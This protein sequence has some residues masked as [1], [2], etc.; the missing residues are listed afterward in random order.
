MSGSLERDLARLESGPLDPGVTVLEAS[1]GTGKTYQITNLVL[2]LVAE[3]GVTMG[4]ILVVTFTNAAT[5]E[6]RDRIRDRLAQA[7]RAL[8]QGSSDDK[9]LDT[10]VGRAGE[11]RETWTRAVARAQEEFDQALISTI[12]GFCQRMLQQHAFESGEEFGLELITDDADLLDELV[13]DYLSARVNTLGAP[14]YAFLVDDCGMDRA[15]LRDV[16][17]AAVSDPDMAL[18]PPAAESPPE[19]WQAELRGLRQAWETE[20]AALAQRFDRGRPLKKNLKDNPGEVIFSGMQ[21]TYTAKATADMEELLLAW[22]D[23]S[24]EQDIL[25]GPD[26]A[27]MSWFDQ[28]RLE[29]LLVE[30]ATF[31]SR[32][33]ALALAALVEAAAFG[34]VR[35]S[36]LV[37]APW[38][39]FAGWVRAEYKRRL[40]QRRSLCFQDLLR[41]LDLALEQSPE[42]VEAIRGRFMAG[43]IDEFQDTDHLQWRIFRRLF[44]G[45][46]R[47]LYLIGDPK[48][49]IYG[50]R[51]ANVH[52]YAAARGDEPPLTIR[53]NYRS[54]ARYVA[55]MNAVMGRWPA[56]LFGHPGI[57][58]VQVGANP[59]RE[60]MDRLIPPGG[61]EADLDVWQDPAA[62]PLQLRFFGDG[63]E[64]GIEGEPGPGI[65][66][67]PGPLTK[68]R[69]GEM[70]PARVAAD[71]VAFL[72]AGFTIQQD[73]DKAPVPV[74]PGDLA[75]LVRGN[76]QAD[77]M[78]AALG[79]AGVPAVRAGAGS[80]FASEEAGHLLQWLRA[81]ASPG[82]DR[83]VRAAAVSPAFGWTA[84]QLLDLDDP[85]QDN[86]RWDLWLSDLVRWQEMIYKHG[87]Q[88]AF[89]RAMADWGVHPRLLALPDG[90]RRITN[91]LHLL[92]L[93]YAAQLDQRLRLD[94]LVRWLSESRSR[95]DT[96]QEVA[97][98]RLERD[99][100]AVKVLTMH[101]SKGLQYPVVFAPFLW[102]GR[103]VRDADRSRLVHPVAEGATER[104]LELQRPPYPEEHQANV[105][106]AEHEAHRE[107]MR[108]L[109]VALTR[110]RLRCVLY[111]GPVTA[112]DGVSGLTRSPLGV[113]LHGQDPDVAAD[114]GA[115]ARYQ[116][117]V[118]RIKGMSAGELR[119]DLD[120]W[121]AL[122]RWR[123][124]GA[125]GGEPPLVAVSDAPLPLE[126]VAKY[127]PAGVD[128]AAL[129]LE[130]RHWSRGN[131]PGST[132]PIDPARRGL[133]RTWRRLS[134]TSIT[135]TMRR[136]EEGDQAPAP[137]LTSGIE[138][139][140]ESVDRGQDHDEL[141]DAVAGASSG[142]L[143]DRLASAR[144]SVPQGQAPVPLAEFPPGPEAGT[145]L[146]AVYELLD[147]QDF[148]R[149]P[150]ETRAMAAG[151]SRLRE[152]LQELGT[153]HGMTEP[154]HLKLLLEHL[155][156]TLQTP[157]GGELGDLRLADIPRGRR[158]DELGFDLPV[159]GG[160][161]HRRRD[162]DGTVTW[163]RRVSGRDFGQAFLAASDPGGLRP[164]YLEQL[165]RGWENHRFAGYLTGTI[166][167]VF[168]TPLHGQAQRF[169]V[170]D[171]KSNKLDLL[172]EGLS[173]PQNFCRPWMLHEM[174]HH[175]YLVQAYLYTV[176]L[177]RF[178]RHRLGAHVYSY[179]RH[180]G[181]AIY[182]FF[183]G[184]TGP[185]SDS[186]LAGGH[187]PG[188]FHHRPPR[189]VIDALDTLLGGEA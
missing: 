81:V 137:V 29:A 19:G 18:D 9:F 72:S 143:Q 38:R 47:H 106:L 61:A 40:E 31:E 146:H 86:R 20:G 166:D 90:E 45:G 64:P 168:A 41:R 93:G 97:E 118:D 112:Q 58:Y 94:G 59:D 2:R 10:F 182:L 28:Q 96:E 151:R 78:V 83:A 144:P 98:L 187:P 180:V 33:W 181:G 15:E 132:S 174:E 148:P 36:N 103:L 46:D 175:A 130:V 136:E 22:V 164:E 120:R 100:A 21:R 57:P 111:T 115:T 26:P 179:D 88:Q 114:P 6:L 1:A 167:L 154:R 32:P 5:A 109:Y 125:P 79:E 63:P 159:A 14:V 27:L 150:G 108:L 134:Y 161:Q 116:G 52:V 12:H 138:P 117:T 124:P 73:A 188:V 127:R 74:T 163:P 62:A 39:E 67:V 155:P 123:G 139:V 153:V 66:G 189:E 140:P 23:A 152:L 48:Q 71:V 142:S 87:L 25:L 122:T 75:V 183:R 145:F 95:S 113:L 157:L 102:D 110:A 141:V 42:L 178:L 84:S 121:A 173:V 77:Q 156:A 99:D 54:D 4:E 107:N 186:E 80:V 7:S 37:T 185:V 68:S 101:K 162:P 16:A 171:Y 50:F 105:R 35:R 165:S 56:S 176:A 17:R 70:L 49:A 55:A 91:L 169:Y 11:Q 51:G 65:E 82:D 184:M 92:E 119:A 8:R 170:L 34:N 129:A 158:L 126:E 13:D 147:F 128:R 24:L 44:G 30:G 89:R 149:E 104:R 133:D 76:F 172:R 60:P 43:L 135:R 160:E 69:A 85:D 53:T 3:A 131:P 177:Q